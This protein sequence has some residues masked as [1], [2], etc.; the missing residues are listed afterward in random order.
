MGFRVC[1]AVTLVAATICSAFE[2]EHNARQVDRVLGFRDEKPRAAFY[3]LFPALWRKRTRI[4]REKGPV[5][6]SIHV[7][8]QPFDHNSPVAEDGIMTFSSSGRTG[9]SLLSDVEHMPKRFTGRRILAGDAESSDSTADGKKGTE[10]STKDATGKG[11]GF[12]NE[13]PK[14][15]IASLKMELKAKNGEVKRLKHKR[16]FLEKALKLKVGQAK[17]HHGEFELNENEIKDTTKQLQKFQKES[18]ETSRKYDEMVKESET[19]KERAL[20]LEQRAQA[21]QESTDTLTVRLQQ[22]TVEDVLQRH[23]RGLPD[24]M[25][26]ALWRSAEVLTPFF[27]TLMIAA[28]TN[29]RLVDH[30]GSEIDKYTH[31]NIRKSPFLSGLLFYSILLIPTLTIVSIVK[32]LWE[33]SGHLTVSHLVIVGNVYFVVICVVCIVASLVLQHD[34]LA[35]LHKN[36]EK[37]FSTFNLFLA[38]YYSWHTTML[39]LQAVYTWE[40]RNWA[41]V[42]ATVCVGVHYFL[43]TWRRVFTN[44][45]PVMMTANYLVYCTIFVFIAFERSQRVNLSWMVRGPPSHWSPTRLLNQILCVDFG[46]VK[47]LVLSS[48]QSWVSLLPWNRRR[49][50]ASLSSR[51]RP[52]QRPSALLRQDRQNSFDDEESGEYAPTTRLARDRVHED[53]SEYETRG[54]GGNGGFYTKNGASLSGAKSKRRKSKQIPTEKPRSSGIAD[55]L[56]GTKHRDDYS[57]DDG[58]SNSSEDYYEDD[59]HDRRDGIDRSSRVKSR[60]HQ[61]WFPFNFTT[62]YTNARNSYG[63]TVSTRDHSRGPSREKRR[64]SS[65]TAEQENWLFNKWK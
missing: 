5:S 42:F 4:L 14:E 32:R 53:N 40:R 65:R 28:D 60:N 16:E 54:N 12:V 36:H 29:Q 19:A 46:A 45:K 61:G 50:K 7:D 43:F 24:S 6:S 56:F 41:Q 9:R 35:D 26:G 30:V 33:T 2:T 44:A 13:D 57:D 64:R 62:N 58:G 3:D 55:M 47:E 52:F 49:T 31:M 8:P 10:G 20:R 27:D 51:N 23:T 1:V 11:P 39:L 15:R 34:P 59:E 48:I 37:L 25:A 17:M 63:S 18:N 38:I 21:L 22:L